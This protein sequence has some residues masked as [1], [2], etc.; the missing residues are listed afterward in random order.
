MGGRAAG[1]SPNSG[2]PFVIRMCGLRSGLFGRH[3]GRGLDGEH[4][5]TFGFINGQVGKQPF[6]A[7]GSGRLSNRSVH[8][9][10]AN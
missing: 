6:G 8:R 9:L 4:A 3:A 2:F 7:A 10:V 1:I 5:R